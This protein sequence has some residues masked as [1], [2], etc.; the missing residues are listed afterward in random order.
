[1]IWQWSKCSFYASFIHISTLNMAKI[2]V[3]HLKA[4]ENE[5]NTAC[6]LNVRCV[7]NRPI[8]V[9]EHWWD[10]YYP[11]Y[12]TKQ[13]LVFQ[14][15]IGIVKECVWIGYLCVWHTLLYD[16]RLSQWA[17]SSVSCSVLLFFFVFSFSFVRPERNCSSSHCQAGTNMH[18]NT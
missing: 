14:F 5:L 10:A 11:N 8:S 4:V 9:K 16:V 18:Q 7:E 3:S 17:E 12:I 1:M 2:H 13:T 15:S 6:L